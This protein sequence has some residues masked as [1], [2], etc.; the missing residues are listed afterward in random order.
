[1]LIDS[2][3]IQTPAAS[4][5]RAGSTGT[6]LLDQDAV[7][8]ALRDACV[9]VGWSAAGLYANGTISYPLGFPVVPGTTIAPVRPVVG[10]RGAFVRLDG[11]SYVFYNPYAETPQAGGPCIFFALAPTM[12]DG[13]DNLCDALSLSRFNA[14]WTSGAG[15]IVVTL[16]AKAPGPAANFAQLVGDGSW[17]VSSSISDGGWALTSV[18][19]RDGAGNLRT[20][21]YTV[22]VTS[23]G[24]INPT[25]SHYTYPLWFDFITPHNALGSLRLPLDTWI[26]STLSRTDAHPLRLGAAGYRIV[27]N[28]YSF[29]VYVPDDDGA[30][31]LFVASPYIPTEE[32]FTSAYAVMVAYPHLGGSTT[33]RNG[34]YV[35]IDGAV[36]YPGGSYPRMLALRSPGTDPLTTP[37]GAPLITTAW[38][39]FGKDSTHTPAVVGR[40]WGCAI[41]NDYV[42]G[43]VIGGVRYATLARQD[44]SLG[45]TRS[46]LLMQTG[47]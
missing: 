2:L 29:A 26:Y 16:T 20:G 21:S 35:G 15:G 45:K 43:A 39:M 18:E 37:S 27:A 44:G 38:V 8:N 7:I 3:A 33:W 32:G 12:A 30:N 40:L 24:G 6:P 46:T 42:D 47:E 36:G 10:C 4:A 34:S 19:D 28:P 23:G 5:M 22:N 13:L 25:T 1:M 9:Q 31:A 11:V 41:A 17:G 14:S